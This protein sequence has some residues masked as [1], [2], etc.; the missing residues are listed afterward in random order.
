MATSPKLDPAPLIKLDRPRPRARKDSP[1]T[2]ELKDFVDRAIVPALV[3][4][5][6]A[7]VDAENK[8]AHQHSDAAHSVRHTAAPE[9]RTMRP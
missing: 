8:L 6:L 4:E 2:P 5:Y 9:Q 7:E 3:K 1:L